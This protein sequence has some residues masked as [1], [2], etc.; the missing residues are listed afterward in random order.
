MGQTLQGRCTPRTAQCP[1]RAESDPVAASPRSVAT[2][3]HLDIRETKPRRSAGALDVISELRV[4]AAASASWLRQ[5]RAV[6][7]YF[8]TPWDVR[9]KMPLAPTQGPCLVTFLFDLG[10]KDVSLMRNP[11]PLSHVTDA[12]LSSDF[13]VIPVGRL[14][15]FRF[16]VGYVPSG[17]LAPACTP[18]ATPSNVTRTAL[19]F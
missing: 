18:M 6:T 5:L 15:L 13:L 1:L 12:P 10:I 9:R 7:R 14:L 16:C 2:G 8:L 11:A 19:P 17:F 4:Q 3:P